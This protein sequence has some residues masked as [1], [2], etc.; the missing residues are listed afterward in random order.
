MINME[1]NFQTG[2]EYQRPCKSMT[3]QRTQTM[4]ELHI[5]KEIGNNIDWN[6]RVK[7]YRLSVRKALEDADQRKRES[8]LKAI[9]EEIR[10]L[11]EIKWGEAVRYSEMSS[12]DRQSIIHAFMFLTEKTLASGDFD[13]WKARLVAGGNEI[14]DVIKEDTYSPTANYTSV[15]T[16]VALAASEKKDLRSYDVKTAYLIPDIKPGE[17]PIFIRVDKEVTK[18]IVALYP[19]WAPYVC[20]NGT[21]VVKLNKYLYGLPTAGRHWYDHLSNTLTRKLGFDQFRGDRCVFQR[22][23]GKERVRLVIWVDDILASG[24]PAALDRFEREL[25]AQ[26]RITSHKERVSYLGLDIAKQSDGG[27]IISSPGTR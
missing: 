24:K 6:R 13:K 21:L 14:E 20:N 7:S 17:K 12:V 26:Y 25:A 9:D 27:Y 22:G 19:G 11:M 15:M 1:L 3:T 5:G 4:R 23:R 10:G 2:E 8:A 16:T 18:R